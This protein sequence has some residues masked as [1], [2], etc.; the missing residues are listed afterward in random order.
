[1]TEPR[2]VEG[3]GLSDEQFEIFYRDEYAAAARLAYL[4]C[5]TQMISDDIVQDSFLAMEKHFSGL[6]HPAAYLR[7][8][9]V[10]RCASWHRTNIRR[11]GLL[12]KLYTDGS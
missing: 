9:V 4:L 2:A 12:H 11:A 7:T 1:M 8:T 6:D 5:G 10:R 3:V